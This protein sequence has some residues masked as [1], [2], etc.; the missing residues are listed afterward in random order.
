MAS[1]LQPWLNWLAKLV[2]M[3][4]SSLKVKKLDVDFASVGKRSVYVGY[5][6]GPRRSDSKISNAEL[7]FV[8][9]SG[10]RPKDVYFMSK[11]DP[12]FRIPPRPFV[13]PGIEKGLDQI[14]EHLKASILYQLDGKE[15]QAESE[16]VLAGIAGENAIRRFIRDYPQNGLAPNA[17]STIKRK[18]EDHPLKGRTGELMRTVTSVIR[19]D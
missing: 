10:V 9:T 3:S 5:P 19:N 6:E 15:E 14:T 18:G 17:P 4:G 7:A 13:E 1:N 11:G 12:R 8:M 16:R 2:C